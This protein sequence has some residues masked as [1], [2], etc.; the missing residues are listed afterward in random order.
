MKLFEIKIHGICEHRGATE[1]INLVFYA[2]FT[3]GR[4]HVAAPRGWEARVGA[5]LFRGT[6]GPTHCEPSSH[7]AC[8]PVPFRE[9]LA[10]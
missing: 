4:T 8:I 2:N 6:E 3:G 5:E 9:V 7:P 1:M 10:L